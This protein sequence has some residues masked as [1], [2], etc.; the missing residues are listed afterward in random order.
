MYEGDSE[1]SKDGVWHVDIH[2]E[3]CMFLL[4]C[5]WICEHVIACALRWGVALV[6][7]FIYWTLL[8]PLW[9]NIFRYWRYTGG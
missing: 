7:E 5:V 1:D 2:V 8:T 3:M 6:G 4:E 9:E